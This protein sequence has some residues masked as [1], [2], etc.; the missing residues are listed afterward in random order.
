VDIEKTSIGYM[1]AGASA[2]SVLTDTE[3]F[4]GCKEDLS[5]ARK[6]NYCPILRK[7]F[8]IDQYQVIEAKSIGADAI[9][10]IAAVLDVN[11]AKDLARF[12]KS[13]G[14]EVLLEVKD[15][16]EIARYLDKNIDIVGVN[17]RNLQSFEVN[18]ETSI[19][20]AEKIP[21][22]FTK[23]SESGISDPSTIM[24]LKNCGYDGFL[25]GEYFMQTSRP[26]IACSDF[27]KKLKELS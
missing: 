3:Y 8:V 6:F 1:Q 9:L 10:L 26:H 23:I 14:L 17:N 19:L 5:I 24:D 2:L 13:L 25:M 4:G 15:E 18:V 12:S 20:L 27:I 21:S 7:D 22:D 16:D 11:Q